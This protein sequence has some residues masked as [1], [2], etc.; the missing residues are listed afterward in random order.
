M[1]A[2]NAGLRINE[3]KLRPKPFLD[4]MI[5]SFDGELEPLIEEINRLL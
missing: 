1:L 4:A 5:S 3:R 2:R